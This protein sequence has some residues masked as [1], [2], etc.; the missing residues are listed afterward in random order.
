MR[1][2]LKKNNNIIQLKACFCSE[3]KEDQNISQQKSLMREAFFEDD[4]IN[5]FVEKGEEPGQKERQDNDG[6]LPGWGSWIGGEDPDLAS[7]QRRRKR[8]RKQTDQ[9][10]MAV[11][12]VMPRVVI[13]DQSETGNSLSKHRVK[14]LP[15]PFSCLPSFESSL[16]SIPLGRDFVPETAFKRV[17]QERISTKRGAI[18]SPM[19][20]E[21]KVATKVGAKSMMTNRKKRN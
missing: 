16:H 21:D 9:K 20:E 3:S 7:N 19:D 1:L 17:T 8:N 12:K 14:T 13:S 10:P 4:V 11:K 6:S 18:I 5:D 2:A 15:F